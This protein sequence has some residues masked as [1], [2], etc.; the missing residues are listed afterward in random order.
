MGTVIHPSWP[1]DHSTNMKYTLVCRWKKIVDTLNIEYQEE[2]WRMLYG[3]RDG[4]RKPIFFHNSCQVVTNFSGK[5]L[6]F[7]HGQA[8]RVSHRIYWNRNS[9]VIILLEYPICLVLVTTLTFP[10]TRSILTFNL[11]TSSRQ[12]SIPLFL[13]NH[14]QMV[15][16]S[17]DDLNSSKLIFM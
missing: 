8:S 7:L 3:E 11:A 17:V 1:M 2:E 14:H 16:L 4:N 10:S 13:T 15:L 12:A 5:A 6:F 9:K